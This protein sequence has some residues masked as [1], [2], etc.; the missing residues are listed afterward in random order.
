MLG[1]SIMRSLST[2][3]TYALGCALLFSTGGCDE[4]ENAYIMSQ[5]HLVTDSEEAPSGFTCSDVSAGTG[6][7]SGG[8]PADDFWMTEESSASGLS[9]EIG[10]L[11]QTL[12]SRFYD[13]AFIAAHAVDR[14]IV[15]TASGD[16]YAF[17][18]WGGDSCQSC[19]PTP[20]EPLPG[21]PF[22]C[23]SADGS[24]ATTR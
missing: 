11:G 13:R 17:V 16:R 14:F 24:A 12:E 20:V 5:M 15:E 7:T 19:P 21:D 18:Y 23:A 4:S 2:T 9:V 6:S 22:G 3:A 8:S 10:S 1:L